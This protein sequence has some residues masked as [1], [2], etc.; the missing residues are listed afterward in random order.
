M[1]QYLSF[2][3]T[4]RVKSVKN[5]KH[6]RFSNTHAR[7]FGLARD[8]CQRSD[9]TLATNEDGG[10]GGENTVSNEHT[11]CKQSLINGQRLRPEAVDIWHQK[12]PNGF[13]DD[14]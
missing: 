8:E 14:S 13:V 7:A 6:S 2:S 1:R 11:I 5:E 4:D 10:S 9:T 3:L 12:Q